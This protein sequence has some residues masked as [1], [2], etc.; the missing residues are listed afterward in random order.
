[1]KKNVF[2]DQL[3]KNAID[4]LKVAQIEQAYGFELPIEVK[5]IIS[6]CNETIFLENNCRFLSFSEII[7]A[8]ND[9]HIAFK[10]K[11][12]LPIA[13]CGENDFI[14]YH[15]RDGFWSKFNIID[16]IIFKKKERLAELLV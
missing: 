7:D 6:V 1:M 3:A 10:E 16:E 8:E 13:D 5:R 4:E 2:F 11:G 14:I 12:I 15:L 9:L